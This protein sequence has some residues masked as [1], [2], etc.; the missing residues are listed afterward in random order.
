MIIYYFVLL[1]SF[2]IADI[3]DTS[4]ITILGTANVLGEIDPCG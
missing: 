2:I 1:L 4:P 3:K